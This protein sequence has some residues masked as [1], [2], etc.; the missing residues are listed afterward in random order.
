MV[1]SGWFW[2]LCLGIFSVGYGFKG[3][4]VPGK[5]ITIIDNDSDNSLRAVERVLWIAS[6]ICEIAVGLIFF[7]WP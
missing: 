7:R 1:V 2:L 4:R 3:E 5:I 6:G